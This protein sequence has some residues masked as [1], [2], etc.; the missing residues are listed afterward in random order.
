MLGSGGVGGAL[1]WLWEIRDGTDESWLRELLDLLM[2]IGFGAG[3]AVVFIY[4]IANNDR[5]DMAKMVALALLS[6][7]VWQAIWSSYQGMVATSS[8]SVDNFLARN[9]AEQPPSHTE[10]EDGSAT[11]RGDT[12]SSRQGTQ[13]R[14][15]IIRDNL[16]AEV[17]RWLGEEEMAVETFEATPSVE[18]NETKEIGGQRF[19]FSLSEAGAFVVHVEASGADDDLVGTLY[20]YSSGRLEVVDIDDDS[21]HG[22]NPKLEVDGDSGDRYLVVL[23]T[24]DEDATYGGPTRVRVSQRLW[25]QFLDSD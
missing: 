7:F 17:E 22:Y 11:A 4:L 24:F 19:R 21:G 16:R 12:V 5:S 6:G 10:R 2:S 20:R 18:V 9:L 23:R 8:K 15:E 25:G 1:V 3:A 14:R 13:S